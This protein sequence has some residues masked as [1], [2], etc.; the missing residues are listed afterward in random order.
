MF[1]E[2]YKKNPKKMYSDAVHIQDACNLIAVSNSF[3]DALK[4]SDR[5]I[6]NPAVMAMFFK[7]YDMMHGP[8]VPEMYNA[9]KECEKRIA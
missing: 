4:A 9:L 8:D 1:E 2:E 7:M 6:K 3:I 5:N